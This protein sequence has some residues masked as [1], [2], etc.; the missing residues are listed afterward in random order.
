MKKLKKVFAALICVAMCCAFAFAQSSKTST[1]TSGLFDTDI[2]NFMDVTGWSSVQPENLFLMADVKGLGVAKQFEKLYVSAYFGG[3]FDEYSSE[4]TAGTADS[5]Y[6]FHNYDFGLLFGFS[7]M[8]IKAYFSPSV[9]SSASGVSHVYV[10]SVR[11]VRTDDYAFE[12]GLQYGISTNL[13]GK[14][15]DQS[16]TIEYAPNVDYSYISQISGDATVTTELL[17]SVYSLNIGSNSSWKISEGNGFTNTAKLAFEGDFGI[18]PQTKSNS[19]ET[20]TGDYEY[21]FELVPA[22][23]TKYEKDWFKIAI[24]SYLS[25]QYYTAGGA[26]YVTKDGVKQYTEVRVIDN[27]FGI[28]P[29]FDIG[30]QFQIAKPVVFN[31]GTSLDLPAFL[32]TNARTLTRNA[33]G[34]VLGDAF[35][36]KF[37][38]NSNQASSTIKFV[39][40]F[41][42]DIGKYVVVDTSYNILEQFNGFY[43]GPAS[44][45]FW[46]T[47]NSI[48]FTYMSIGVSVKF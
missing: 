8:A 18:I 20:C 36:K 39:S 32:W 13:A 19:L 1:S 33:S 6:Q 22:W 3:Y 37:Y 24:K 23:V 45:N 9:T 40:G 25:M 21:N 30:A 4:V 48:L 31:V 2:D 28:V 17:T 7:N 14:P 35:D 12:A 46:E 11:T 16:I 26:N 44:S 43:W 47:V 5:T 34:A 41:T 10:D 29:Q 27:N 15:F 38:I 42:F